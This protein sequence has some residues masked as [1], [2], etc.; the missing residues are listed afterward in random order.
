VIDAN[1]SGSIGKGEILDASKKYGK[2]R[3]NLS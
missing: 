1:K 2:R 3:R